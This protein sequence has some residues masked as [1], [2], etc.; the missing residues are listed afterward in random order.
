MDGERARKRR[1]ELKISGETIA[2]KLNTTKA[3]VSRWESGVSEPDDKTK[4]ALA[5]LL[6][7]TVA[8][9]L[10]EIDNPNPFA[11]SDDGHVDTVPLCSD[12]D[13]V[14]DTSKETLHQEKPGHLIFRHGD[15]VIDVP[16]TPI[17]QS[18]FRELTA[19][20]LMTGMAAKATA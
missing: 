12:I 13:D 6:N 18:W 3:T 7:T 4:L 8:Y 9:L 10:G 14:P 1:K 5:K 20:L 19:N 2:Q 17:N 16:D 15:C 11:L